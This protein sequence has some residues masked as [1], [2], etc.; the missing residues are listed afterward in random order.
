MDNSYPVQLLLLQLLCGKQFCHN[1]GKGFDHTSLEV[2]RKLH[3]LNYELFTHINKEDNIFFDSG[4]KVS[5]Y[6]NGDFG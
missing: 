3:F 4:N 2:V 1:S 5:Q 6:F